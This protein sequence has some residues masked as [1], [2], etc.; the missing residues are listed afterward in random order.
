MHICIGG[1]IWCVN[2]WWCFKSKYC[3]FLYIYDIFFVHK[4]YMHTYKCMRINKIIYRLYIIL[5]LTFHIPQSING[6]TYKSSRVAVS[7]YHYILL[8]T[9]FYLLLGII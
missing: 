8:H 3:L 5:I 4:S 1:E 6:Q 7:I 9:F 2:H